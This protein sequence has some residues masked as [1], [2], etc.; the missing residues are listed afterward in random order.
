MSEQNK[1]LTDIEKEA[2]LSWREWPI[3]VVLRLKNLQEIQQKLRIQG[4]TPSQL[5]R[6][7]QMLILRFEEIDQRPAVL[8]DRLHRFLGIEP[9]PDDVDGLGV[10]NPSENRGDTLD[11]AL[12]RE[13]TARYADSNRRL[14]AMLGPEFAMW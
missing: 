9:R 10:I 11:P 3:Y 5:V 13:L 7:D 12:R 14:A 1:T 6:R 8:A 2:L 4:E